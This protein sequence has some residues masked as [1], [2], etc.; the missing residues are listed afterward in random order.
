MQL[1]KDGSWLW[2]RAQNQAVHLYKYRQRMHVVTKLGRKLEARHCCVPVNEEVATIYLLARDGTAVSSILTVPS[3]RFP[4]VRHW[5]MRY[6]PD[7]AWQPRMNHRRENNVY[8]IISRRDS[9]DGLRYR[10]ERLSETW[11]QQELMGSRM[12]SLIGNVGT[13]FRSTVSNP[14]DSFRFLW[15]VVVSA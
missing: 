10:V 5:R 4:V 8:R 2:P 11:E 12:E 15:H 3:S 1:S 7:P 9:D 6:W 14:A 13:C